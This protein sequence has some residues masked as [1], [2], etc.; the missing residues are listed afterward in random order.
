MID[1]SWEAKQ[2]KLSCRYAWQ[3]EWGGTISLVAV[4]ADTGLETVLESLQ[5]TNQPQTKTIKHGR[6]RQGRGYR[7][8][9]R[10]GENEIPL[11][12]QCGFVVPYEA[13]IK[14]HLGKPRRDNWQEISVRVQG[15]LPPGSLMVGRDNGHRFLLPAQPKG[16]EPY[17]FWLQVQSEYQARLYCLVPVKSSPKRVNTL[18]EL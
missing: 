10:M 17:R 3:P 8:V 16:N 6:L 15:A 18:V 12:K 14:Y 11:E 1:V 5:S 13:Q 4:E 7:I 9:C 2:A